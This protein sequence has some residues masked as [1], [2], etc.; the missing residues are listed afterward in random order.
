[1]TTKELIQAEMAQMNDEQLAEVYA[2]MRHIAQDPQQ[3]ATES[4]FDTL[5]RIRIQGPAD[6]ST[7]FE[8]YMGQDAD[9][10]PDISSPVI[11]CSDATQPA[12]PTRSGLCLGM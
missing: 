8:R 5:P 4:I 10:E 6:L 9:D 12:A 1:M 11:A 2:L 3:P 7:N